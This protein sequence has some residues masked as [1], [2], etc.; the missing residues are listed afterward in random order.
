MLCSVS[1]I[2]LPGSIYRTLCCAR[3]ETDSC[4]WGHQECRK[5][6]WWERQNHQIGPKSSENWQ[7]NLV[8][9]VPPD[10]CSQ[11]VA[12]APL[13]YLGMLTWPIVLLLF[14]RIESLIIL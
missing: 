12:A 2:L 3:Y 14:L 10:V 4:C 8:A 9:L 11:A 1:M 6:S 7:M 13:L 5:E